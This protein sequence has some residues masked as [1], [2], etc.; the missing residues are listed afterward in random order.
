[1]SN[2]CKKA[3]VYKD[4]SSGNLMLKSNEGEKLMNLFE[5]T[6]AILIAAVLAVSLIYTLALGRQKSMAEGEIDKQIDKP[7]QQ[8]VYV[9]NPIFLSY[10]IFFALCLFIILFIAMEFY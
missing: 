6:L 9:K 2:Y 4:S 7:I 1:M 8:N 5:I 10:G 3:A